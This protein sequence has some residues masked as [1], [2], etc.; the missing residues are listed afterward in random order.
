MRMP[1]S[2]SRYRS[3]GKSLRI[4]AVI[5]AVL[6]VGHCP[7]AA[8]AADWPQWQGPDR[9]AMSKEKGLL[10]EWPAEGPPLAW[11]I[12]GLGGGDSSPSIAGGRIFGM[13]NR[14][15]QEVVW[16]LSERD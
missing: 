4:F 9:N 12:K 3:I 10:Q 2:L 8:T 7:N 1:K 16:A 5:A 14:G 13:S 15:D 11:R 6:P